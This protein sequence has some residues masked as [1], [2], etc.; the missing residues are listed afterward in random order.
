MAGGTIGT[1]SRFGVRRHASWRV[2]TVTA[3]IF[4]G[5]GL[6][7]VLPQY[8]TLREMPGD[9]GDGRFII[10]TLEF[11][12]RT[13]IDAL[14]GREA[15]FLNA[16]FFYPW[17]RVTNFGDTFWGDWE[18]YVLARS[19]GLGELASFQI[20]T[21]A[22]FVLTFVAAFLSFRKLGMH[23]CGA[24]AGAF[25]FTFALPVTAQTGHV[26]LL[27]RLW[28]PPSVVALDHFLTRS[29]VR[30]GALCFLF[31]ALQFAANVYLGLFLCL[32][33]LAYIA[34]VFL[35]GR[36]RVALPSLAQLRSI[37]L[38][39]H[40][41]TA[42]IFAAGLAILAVVAIPYRE[43]QLL[44]GFERSFEEVTIFLPRLGSYLLAS[45]SRIWPDLS[46][47]FRYAG[48]WEHNLFPGLAAIVAFLFFLCRRRGESAIRLLPPCSLSPD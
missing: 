44:Y 42:I 29:S 36:N 32:L 7:L 5:L 40:G 31:L 16:P 14:H 33:L 8:V 30:A 18:V 28:I 3:V 47:S 6:G 25:L 19:L 23:P 11:F 34:A 10:A 20:W 2:E 39:A 41:G 15:N 43:V 27:Y 21:V 35:V 45:L 22:G 37:S 4:L 24:A 13:L 9:L 1:F 46:S 26:Q 38:A 12:Y 48:S 17:P